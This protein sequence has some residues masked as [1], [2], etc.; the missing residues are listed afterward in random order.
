[1]SIEVKNITKLYGEQKALDNVSFE[2]RTGQIVGFLGPNGAGK[3]TMMKILTGFIPPTSGSAKVCGYDILTQ[4]ME[5]KRSVGYL[6]ESNPLY[7]DMYVKEYLHFVAGMHGI[8]S[9]VNALVARM[10]EMTGLGLEQKKKIRMLSKGYKQRVGLAQALIHDPKVLILDEPTSG[11]DPNQLVEIRNLIK[12]LGKEKT[13]MLSTHIMQE[14]EAMC[15]QVII[16]NRGKI[17]ANQ[18]IDSIQ[19]AANTNKEY[20]EVE[21]EGA[22]NE[23]LLMHISGVTAVKKQTGNLWLIESE[24][25]HDIRAALFQWAVA[26]QVTVLTLK[27]HETSLEE[28]FQ[29]VTRKKK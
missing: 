5:V 22:V 24:K 1:M 16:I 8:H 13:V 27:K 20:V 12:E 10:I 7:G 11:L 3:S 19:Q 29:Q 18:T 2:I 9:N 28:V 25:G 4:A 21:L 6:P 15:E 26:N 14:V 17:E 23:N